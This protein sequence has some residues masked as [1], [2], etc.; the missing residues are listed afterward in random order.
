VER[1]VEVW[2]PNAEPAHSLY[3]LAIVG[4]G[5]VGLGAAVYAASDG[6]STIVLEP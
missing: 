6:L 5:P 2:K 4:A 1:L 3:D